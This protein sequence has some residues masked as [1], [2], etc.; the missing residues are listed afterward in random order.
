MKCG[1]TEDKDVK[2]SVKYNK[3]GI[4]EA[5]WAI[6][7]AE[8]YFQ[9]FTIEQGKE[10]FDYLRELKV[11]NSR[12]TIFWYFVEREK[13]VYNWERHD[14]LIDY[15]HNEIGI[16]VIISI[17]HG[18]GDNS[19]Y[20]CGPS[21]VS[22]TDY[23]QAWLNYVDELI[24]R[25][26][27][28]VKKWEIGNEEDSDIFWDI[29]GGPASNPDQFS[30]HLISTANKIRS[31]QTDAYIIMGGVTMIDKDG[32]PN[33]CEDCAGDSYSCDFYGCIEFLKEC[34]NNGVLDYI[35]AVG[36]HPYR[37]KPEIMS[38]VGANYGEILVLPPDEQKPYYCDTGVICSFEDGIQYIRDIIAVDYN[39]PNIDLWDTES[40]FININYI[41]E[42]SLNAQM[43]F[44][45]RSMLVEHAAGLEGLI[46]FRLSVED[47]CVNTD[48]YFSGLIEGVSTLEPR[49]AFNAFKVLAQHIG[50][51]SVVYQRT[52]KG[53]FEDDNLRIELYSDNG[54]AV[55]AYWYWIDWNYDE[56]SNTLKDTKTISFEID[57]I[58][59]H[60]YVVKDI[61]NN[62]TMPVTFTMTDTGVS[63]TNLPITDYPFIIYVDD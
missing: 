4:Q 41:T 30:D 21:L 18:G 11:K 62:V 27:D 35:D 56:I 9:T 28:K 26:G 52:I 16:E 31:I 37:M 48:S 29:E 63:F 55:I 47:P 51:V 39:K 10:M 43:K 15:L 19:L 20:G 38:I 2:D 24:K 32:Y 34:F 53:D 13:G 3:F 8:P 49:P 6:W 57:G 42:K 46:C 59:E 17:G 33:A 1:C 50:A 7:D 5:K 36:F 61:H 25:Y 23:H 40:G 44:I 58:E 12:Y 54:K 22:D 45:T 14:A 60:N